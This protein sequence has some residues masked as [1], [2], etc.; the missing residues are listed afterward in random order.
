MS[1]NQNAEMDEG[2]PVPEEPGSSI[3]ASASDESDEPI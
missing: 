3:A 2:S 1:N